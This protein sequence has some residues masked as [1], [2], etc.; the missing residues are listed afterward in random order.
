MLDG[1]LEVWC[2]MEM[3]TPEDGTCNMTRCV[4]YVI[5]FHHGKVAC[6]VGQVIDPVFASSTTGPS[7]AL[8]K[9]GLNNGL[10]SNDTTRCCFE[11][12]IPCKLFAKND[13]RSEF[14]G[15]WPHQTWRSQSSIWEETPGTNE[16]K[17]NSVGQACFMVVFGLVW[18][19]M[20]LFRDHCSEIGKAYPQSP[21]ILK[22][23]WKRY[24]TSLNA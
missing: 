23:V 17:L 6:V 2:R 18:R 14:W 1:T 15:V 12:C 19:H 10:T 21:W 22:A 13:W 8:E 7:S 3:S 20:I 16:T 24:L 4:W 9:L 11:V 5:S